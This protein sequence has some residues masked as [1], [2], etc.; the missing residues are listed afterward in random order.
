[1]SWKAVVTVKL[2]DTFK[3]NHNCACAD[4]SGNYHEL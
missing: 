4:T 2:K 3:Q 1:M